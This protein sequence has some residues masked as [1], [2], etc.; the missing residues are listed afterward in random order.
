MEEER[1]KDYLKG[2]K[3]QYDFIHED[4]VEH[5]LEEDIKILLKEHEKLK[6]ALNK[7]KKI[8]DSIPREDSICGIEK[9]HDIE[10]IGNI[11]E[12]EVGE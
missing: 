9:I 11:Y 7:I 2:Y 1:L 4:G 5:S 12:N 3:S 6:C 10:V 8:C